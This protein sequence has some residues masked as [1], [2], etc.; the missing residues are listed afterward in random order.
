MLR[1]VWVLTNLNLKLFSL[2]YMGI[3]LVYMLLCSVC[4]VP[5]RARRGSSDP[6]DPL[7]SYQALTFNFCK[8]K[9]IWM[10]SK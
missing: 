4:A 2:M 5:L 1:V 8:Q 6:L 10:M 7:L 9:I 3:L